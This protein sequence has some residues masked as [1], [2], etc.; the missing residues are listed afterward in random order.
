MKEHFKKLV[1]ISRPRFWLYLGGTFGV[2]YA[3]GAG[4]RGDFLNWQFFYMLI[5]FLFPAN[6]FLYGINDLFDWET[7]H[8]NIKKK[9]KEYSLI[10]SDKKFLQISV[11]IS[12]LLSLPIFLY[13]N[14]QSRIWIV[15]FLFLSFF[16]SAEPLRFKKSPILDFS[17]NFLYVVP[18]IVAYLQHS[19]ELNI[20]ILIASFCWT[21]AMHLFSA[22]P[23]IEPDS[24]AGIKTTAV[25]LGYD[26]S[27]L[28]CN[29]F[30]FVFS[31]ILISKSLAFIPTLAYPL[32]PLLLLTK[33][34]ININKVYWYFPVITGILGFIAFWYFMIPKL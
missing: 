3:L 32:I 12:I 24:K 11:L 31:F 2:G 34:S 9:S 26:I 27:L 30:W 13:A 21:A 16:Y 25:V 17:S 22:V 8:L 14:S 15:L 1:K 29:L 20:F 28:L 6:I 5:Y 7:D 33:R 18:G 19:T 10:E 23:D 4:G